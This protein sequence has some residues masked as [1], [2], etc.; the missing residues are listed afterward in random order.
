M[1]L[2]SLDAMSGFGK[3]ELRES[4]VGDDGR[5]DWLWKEVGRGRENVL[6]R[7]IFEPKK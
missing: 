6:R 7:N 1:N 4:A 3:V 5:I 2:Q